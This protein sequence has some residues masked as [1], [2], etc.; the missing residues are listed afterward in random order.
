MLHERLR[1]E[2]KLPQALDTY[3]L[4]LK[5]AHLAWTRELRRTNPHRDHSQIASEAL[6]LAIDYLQGDLPFESPPNA[7]EAEALSLDEAMGQL[8]RV[9][10]HA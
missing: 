2:R 6:E 9:S 7:G 4:T 8:Q 5:G 1:R 3:A 10:P